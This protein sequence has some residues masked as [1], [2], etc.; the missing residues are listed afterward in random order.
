MELKW[1]LSIV[2]TMMRQDI[3]E[4]PDKIKALPSN[5]RD[6][7]DR[8]YP[9]ADEL[10]C[11]LNGLITVLDEDRNLLSSRGFQYPCQLGDSLLQNL[12]WTDINLSYDNHDRHIQCKRDTQVL[13]E[14]PVSHLTTFTKGKYGHTCSF[15]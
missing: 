3:Q 4:G 5:V 12:R 7:K 1:R 8:T 6:L 9:L 14:C 10:G 13:S 11:G 2:I 15:L